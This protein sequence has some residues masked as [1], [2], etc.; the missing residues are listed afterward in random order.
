MSLNPMSIVQKAPSAVMEAVVSAGGFAAGVTAGSYLVGA[1]N[2]AVPQANVNLGPVQV[3]LGDAVAVLAGVGTGIYAAKGGNAIIKNFAK[4]AAYGLAGGIVVNK[5]AQAA[6]YP[7]PFQSIMP[8]GG[9]PAAFARSRQL[10]GGRVIPSNA[11]AGRT[12][13]VN[14]A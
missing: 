5:V 7:Q 3:G 11:Y 4:N 8:A 10:Y 1:I 6:G 2:Q 14:P 12:F 9:A 13:A